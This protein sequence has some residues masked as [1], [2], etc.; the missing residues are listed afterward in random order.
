MC[1]Y[2]ALMGH[3]CPT[4]ASQLA[5]TAPTNEAADGVATTNPLLSSLLDVLTRDPASPVAGSPNASELSHT[6]VVQDTSFFDALLQLP[7][8][9]QTSQVGAQAVFDAIGHNASGYAEAASGCTYH[10]SRSPTAPQLLHSRFISLTFEN[11]GVMRQFLQCVIQRT[12]TAA[13]EGT[14]RRLLSTAGGGGLVS[15]PTH[16]CPFGP[17]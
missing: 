2:N 13:P 11:R 1:H 10:T 9:G 3:P 6:Y 8:G 7:P 12:R 4:V 15:S 16:L 17:P 5:Q 14:R